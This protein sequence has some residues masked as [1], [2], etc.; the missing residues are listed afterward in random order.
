M[1][2]SFFILEGFFIVLFA[3]VQISISLIINSKYGLLPPMAVGGTAI[4]VG[5]GVNLMY[6]PNKK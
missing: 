6:N 2:M 1:S 5:R 3:L 4:A